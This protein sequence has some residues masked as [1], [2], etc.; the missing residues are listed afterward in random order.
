[1]GT[2]KRECGF[3]CSEDC[4]RT[5]CPGHTLKLSYQTTA[6]VGRVEHDGVLLY[7]FDP[8]SWKAMK[9]MIDSFFEDY[10]GGL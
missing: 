3:K 1:M 4:R 10:Q 7:S 9:N 8:Q 2:W 5:G 6:E